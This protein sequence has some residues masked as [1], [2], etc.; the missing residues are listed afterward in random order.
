MGVSGWN[1]KKVYD[2]HDLYELNVNK[3]IN[4]LNIDI[5]S[6]K[7]KVLVIDG[8]KEFQRYLSLLNMND[9]Q[10]MG[11]NSQSYA[12]Q[13][14]CY[15]NREESM[16]LSLKLLPFSIDEINEKLN[17]IE[18]NHIKISELNQILQKHRRCFYHDERIIERNRT[19]NSKIYKHPN[20][21]VK[22]NWKK[23][24]CYLQILI[25]TEEM[26]KLINSTKFKE[27]KDFLHFPAKS[28]IEHLLSRFNKNG[29]PKPYYYSNEDEFNSLLLLRAKMLKM[30]K[31]LK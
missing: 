25:E 26:Y 12:I 20:K 18:E 11:N 7:Y 27:I 14:W 4:D 15:L 13:R 28:I 16:S 9:T 19:W 5:K 8:D 22:E 17:F 2:S 29:F 10:G 23:R 31:I 21:K 6:P 24:T 1:A 3:I 30:L